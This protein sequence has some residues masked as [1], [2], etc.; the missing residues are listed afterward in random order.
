LTYD[1]LFKNK[2]VVLI[3]IPGAF[4]PVCSSRH[5]PDFIKELNL[6]VA[7]GIHAVYCLDTN[8]AYTNEA[9][10]VELFKNAKID[11]ELE[12]VFTMLSDGN[13]VFIK[14][15]DIEID[16]RHK[17][18]GVRSQ[19][20]ASLIKDGVVRYIGTDGEG[21][22]VKNASVEAIKNWLQK[23]GKNL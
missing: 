3:G 12:K 17:S 9:W 18:M 1:D 21:A 10:R 16:L 22:E 19:R 2:F 23:Y 20:F 7:Q 5:I 13:G 4:T 8:D 14:E 11:P 6:L 15:H